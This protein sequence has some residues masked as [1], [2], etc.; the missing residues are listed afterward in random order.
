MI[1]LRLNS[2]YVYLLKQIISSIIKIFY[3][4]KVIIYNEREFLAF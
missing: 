1:F 3:L 2:D 4:I